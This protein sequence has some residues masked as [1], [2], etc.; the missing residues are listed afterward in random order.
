MISPGIEPFVLRR[1]M[2]TEMRHN[3]VVHDP[4]ALFNIIDQQRRDRSVTEAKD[5][6]PNKRQSG[7][8][9]DLSLIHI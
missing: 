3:L 7:V 4:D 6:T 5:A 2:E 1:K 8:T 9:L